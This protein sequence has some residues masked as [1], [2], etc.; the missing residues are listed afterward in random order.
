MLST[1]FNQAVLEIGRKMMENQPLPGPGDKFWRRFPSV[2]AADRFTIYSA[3]RELAGG[4]MTFD[5]LPGGSAVSNVYGDNI[6]PGGSGGIGPLDS[7]EG[8]VWTRVGAPIGTG[9]VWKAIR[10][11][12]D[13]DITK[14]A[15]VKM[16]GQRMVDLLSRYFGAGTYDPETFIYDDFLVY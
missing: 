5:Q 10:L 2:S 6:L 3:A 4:G 14:D 11:T 8:N 13:W 16:L 1:D 15:L 12:F 7:N 9:V